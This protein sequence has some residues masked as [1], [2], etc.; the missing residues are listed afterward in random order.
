M[1]T[2]TFIKHREIKGDLQNPRYLEVEECETGYLLNVNIEGLKYTFSS[3][4]FE[5]PK[6][7]G[8]HCLVT[9]RDMSG[10][11]ALIRNHQQSRELQYI[12]VGAGLGE[13][14]PNLIRKFDSLPYKPII[15]DPFNY[16]LATE[17]M[18]YAFD[19]VPEISQPRLIELLDRIR[20]IKDKNK[21][22]LINTKLSEAIVNFPEIMGISD[23]VLDSHGA[24]THQSGETYLSADRKERKKIIKNLL[25]SL[26]KPNAEILIE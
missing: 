18:E 21:I 20:I 2:M 19:K 26:G 15:I 3:H 12:D 14:T 22:R 1:E 23:V 11:K 10:Y 9:A 7:D 4:I 16:D 8:E 17:M 6:P 24:Y 5:V 13:F 25:Y